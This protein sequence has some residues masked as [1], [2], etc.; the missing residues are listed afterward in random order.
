MKDNCMGSLF[1]ILAI[2]TDIKKIII[3]YLSIF[4][5]GCLLLVASNLLP[6]EKIRDN[7]ENSVESFSTAGDYPYMGIEDVPHALDNW[8]EASLLNAMYVADDNIPLYSAFVF[9]NYFSADLT[10]VQR[11]EK[12]MEK[13]DAAVNE[14]FQERTS[15]WIGYTAILR[16]LMC[17]FTYDTCRNLL[18]V[19]VF[20]LL[21]TVL[22]IVGRYSR[23]ISIALLITFSLFHF[24]ILSLEFSQGIFCVI[25]ALFSILYIFKKEISD[26]CLFF[27]I[28]ALL[29]AYFDWFSIP[30]VTYGLPLI[31]IIYKNNSKNKV[32]LVEL[33]NIIW[34]SSLGWAIGYFIMI[35]SKA[36][37][38]YWVTG[39][40]PISF[41]V[42]RI[43]ADTSVTSDT[44]FIFQI[45]DLLKCVLPFSLLKDEIIYGVVVFLIVLSIAI[46]IL[47]KGIRTENIGY[48]IIMFSPIP[49]Y[50]VFRGHIGHIG[51]DY[52]TFMISSF[53]LLMLVSNFIEYR[54]KRKETRKFG[55]KRANTHQL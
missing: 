50:L 52:R 15:N 38:V 23:K 18:N 32:L 20:I 36:I 2:K 53:A 29:S 41:F 39:I 12:L 45:C 5:V 31:C 13:K 25:I 34:N 26:Y 22:V 28:I 30:F 4:C 47:Y 33:L 40:N 35:L 10:G 44:S 42:E 27:F 55:E 51:I 6:D 21:F 3:A 43:A 19:M 1:K 7:I 14:D 9:K 8:T 24:Y 16:L 48:F 49:W 54:L 37:P 11:L 46:I 17:F